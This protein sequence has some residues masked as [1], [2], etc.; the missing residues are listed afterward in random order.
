[1][2]DPKTARRAVYAGVAAMLLAVVATWMQ[3]AIVYHGWIIL[4]IAAGFLV[5]IPLSRVPLTAVPQRT[6]ISHA[7]GGLAAGLVG[8]A[9]YYLWYSE[10]PEQLTRF[11]MA[12]IVAEII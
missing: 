2:N 7:F 12:A 6:A 10:G 3:P 8:T 5:G 4:A 11:R 1:M 9:K